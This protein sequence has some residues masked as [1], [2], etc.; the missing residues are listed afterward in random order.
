MRCQQRVGLLDP[1]DADEPL[2]AQVLPRPE[3]GLVDRV[4]D[5]ERPHRR[6][7]GDQ[8]RGAAAGLGEAG[9]AHRHR[10]DRPLVAPRIPARGAGQGR[11]RRRPLAPRGGHEHGDADDRRP[12]EAPVRLVVHGH[13]ALG[14]HHRVVPGPGQVL[15]PRQVGEGERRDVQ[16]AELVGRGW[17]RRGSRRA[18]RPGRPRPSAAAPAPT[19]AAARRPRGRWPRPARR[20]APRTPRPSA[21]STRGRAP[22]RCAPCGRRG[23]P[24]RRGPRRGA[25]SRRSPRPR[26][27]RNGGRRSAARSS[28]PPRRRPP[29]R[30]PPHCFHALSYISSAPAGSSRAMASVPSTLSRS[31]P[32][33]RARS[34]SVNAAALAASPACSIQL[35]ATS[36]LRRPSSRSGHRR[37]DS[38][39]WRVALCHCWPAAA[40]RANASRSS[41]S[42]PSRAGAAATRWCSTATSP[43]TSAAAAR[44]S[45]LPRAGP[46]AS[47]TAERTSGCGKASAHGCAAV[48]ATSRPRATASSTACTGSPTSPT[49][50]ASG[51]GERIPRT[52]AASTS[53]R[54]SSAH[55]A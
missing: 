47:W 46:R 12:G 42:A 10:H 35:S 34:S 3:P 15:G 48:S 40:R 53:R 32:A 21:P 19:G 11:L 13:G 2:G 30:V 17:R 26:A 45:A 29:D 44:C 6:E 41:A 36:S 8:V 28:R 7:G 31:G 24:A 52:A 9:P 23:S 16:H 1:A 4:A 14:V 54:V 25:T 43:S 51:N 38:T 18:R 5:G 39:R 20:R 27:G 33:G 55:A 37:A 22:G 49:L 50:A